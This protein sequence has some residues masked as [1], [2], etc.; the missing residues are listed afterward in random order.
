M[1][2]SRFNQPNKLSQIME[3]RKIY[4]RKLMPGDEVRVIAPSRSLAIIKNDAREIAE[5]NF[6]SI[7]LKLSFGK[8]VDEVDEFNSSSIKS[9]IEDFHEAFADKN[10]KAILTT[11]GGYNCNQLLD[12]IDWPLVKE[13]PKIFCGYSDITILHNAIF[14]KTGLVTYYG[15]HYSTFGQL[16]FS[17]Y[18]IEYFKKCLFSNDP[19]E[20]LPSKE[21][22]DDK[23]YENQTDRKLIK[24]S[25]ILII[26]EGIASGTVF[27]ANLCTLNLLQGTGYFPD[28]RNSILFVEDTGESSAPIF[29]RDLQSLVQTPDFKKVKGLLIGRFQKQSMITDQILLKIIRNKRELEKIPI[30]ANIDFGHTDPKATIPVGGKMTF[31]AENG[32]S[33]LE[34]LKH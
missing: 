34:I 11:I 32:S 9:R 30:L 4:P 22:T 5:K 6:S 21:W 12:Y 33:R 19:Y 18:T 8:H 15:P 7:G 17:N 16:H 20:I 23:W 25:G 10:V 1:K 31:F 14:S 26:N 28:L 3:Y 13:N 29:D 24:N 2:K 27:T